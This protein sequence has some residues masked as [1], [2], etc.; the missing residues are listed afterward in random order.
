MGQ[1]ADKVKLVRLLTGD[2]AVDDYVFTDDEMESFLELSNGNVYYAAADA[3]DAIAANAAYTLK[4]L[5]ILDV[6]TNG[7][8]TAEAIRASAAALRTKA[9]ADAANTIVCGVVNVVTPQLP[10]HWRPWWEALA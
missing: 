10:T 9:D 1:Y 6:T 4:V 8:A 3:L 7:Q 2:K 5:T